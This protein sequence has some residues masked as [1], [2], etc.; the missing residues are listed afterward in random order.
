[1]RRLKGYKLGSCSL[2]KDV[3]Y[4]GYCMDYYDGP[5]YCFGFWYF[6]IYLYP[7]TW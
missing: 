3:R 7:P 5:V 2:T 6:H 1:M 4:V